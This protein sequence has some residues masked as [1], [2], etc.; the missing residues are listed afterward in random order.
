MD[1]ALSMSLY[2]E[3]VVNCGQLKVQEASLLGEVGGHMMG[4]ALTQPRTQSV[5]AGQ[6]TAWPGPG[7]PLALLM[8]TLPTPGLLRPAAPTSLCAP[9]PATASQEKSHV[10]S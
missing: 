2:S 5:S 9:L 7:G 3:H 8:Q 6:L 10:P 1:W 4:V